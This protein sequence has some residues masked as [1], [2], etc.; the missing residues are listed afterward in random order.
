MEGVYSCYKLGET[1]R[2]LDPNGRCVAS[3][4]R[5]IDADHIVEVLNH[6]TFGL[7]KSGYRPSLYPPRS[8]SLAARFK[9]GQINN[10]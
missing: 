7:P 10:G 9:R 3:C 5:K 4:R 6:T 2:V 1:Y 8:D